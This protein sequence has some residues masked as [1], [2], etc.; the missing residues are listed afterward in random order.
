MIRKMS[1]APQFS[2][3]GVAFLSGSPSERDVPSMLISL[4]MTSVL[5]SS[6]VHPQETKR[7]SCSDFLFK[8]EESLQCLTVLLEVR[9]QF[10]IVLVEGAGPQCLSDLK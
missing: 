4:G 3:K 2:E 10:L 1:S 5:V 8:L 9:P 7:H 6:T